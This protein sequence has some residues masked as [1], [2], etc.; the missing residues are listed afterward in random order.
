MYDLPEAASATDAWWRGL[1]GAMTREGL[2]EVP[3]RLTR[4]DDYPAL[5]RAPGLLFSQTC[6]YPL[7]HTY[8]D[9]LRLVATPAYSAPGCRGAE[10]CSLIV[11]R[12]DCAAAG[13]A[14]LKGCVAAYNAP[15]SQSGYSALRA[16]V[17]PLAGG[18]GFFART[19][20]SGSHAK[21]LELVVRGKADV[22]A[23]DCVSFALLA[24][25]RPA[26]VHGLRTLAE[27]PAAPGLPY[28]TSATNDEDT[29]ARLRTA[30][31][32]ALADPNLAETRAALMIEGAEVLE[33]SHYARILELERAAEELGY[34]ELA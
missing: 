12:D 17:A 33:D 2:R 16:S 23:V 6:G 27:S 10:Y 20:E 1:A 13:P 29:L 30:V 21:S 19:I 28:V 9:D 8:K 34:P 15:E 18:Q 22:C 3:A 4:D 14:D 32:A 25:Y 5:W 26:V 7:T 24:R 31:F 11:V